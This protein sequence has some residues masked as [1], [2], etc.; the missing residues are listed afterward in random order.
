MNQIKVPCPKCG[1]VLYFVEDGLGDGIC[2]ICPHIFSLN[3][4][5]ELITYN[6]LLDE[7]DI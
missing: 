2:P 3:P 5:Y 1:R 6:K 4:A 7:R